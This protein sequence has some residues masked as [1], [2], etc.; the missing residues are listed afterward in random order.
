[1]ST[2]ACPDGQSPHVADP[3][4]GVAPVRWRAMTRPDLEPAGA[5]H[6]PEQMKMPRWEDLPADIRTDAV[7]PYYDVL[8]GRPRQLRL[9]RLLDLVGASALALALGWLFIVLAVVIKLDSPG[10][11]FFRQ[12]RVTRF[13]REF[14]IFKFRTMTHQPCGTG[15]LISTGDDPRVTRA[16][17]FMRRY[18]LDEIPQLIDVLRGTMTFVG[19]RPEV[20]EYVRRYSPEMRATLLLPAGVTS[21][22][23]IRFKN[24]AQMLAAVSDVDSTYVHRILPVKM[25]FNLEDIREFSV[26]RDLR[27]AL[28]TIRAVLGGG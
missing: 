15:A 21:T 23:S 6:G 28:D 24:E 10:P 25:R 7:R 4:E 13:G 14:R 18:R 11:V 22:A 20:P 3:P 8:V 26:R 12:R 2:K 19:T 27:I 9:K 16:G 17:R 5:E 1:M